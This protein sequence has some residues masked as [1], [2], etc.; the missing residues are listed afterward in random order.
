M[1]GRPCLELQWNKLDAE[2]SGRPDLIWL[3]NNVEV[4][5]F[6]EHIRPASEIGI[7]QKMIML[8][9]YKSELTTKAL[10]KGFI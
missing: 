6:I 9:N 2:V 1:Q 3:R 4:F 7:L 5:H 10:S 8:S